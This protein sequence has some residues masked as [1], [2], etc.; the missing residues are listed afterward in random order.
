[1]RVRGSGYAG[2][3]SVSFVIRLLQGR[4]PRGVQR[5]LMFVQDCVRG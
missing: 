3:R 1:M 2:R 4:S 5:M